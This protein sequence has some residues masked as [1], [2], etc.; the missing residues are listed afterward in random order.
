MI[1]FGGTKH[2]DESINVRLRCEN[3][4]L[5]ANI[6]GADYTGVDKNRGI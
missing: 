1:L 4:S 2:V 5:V 6:N 3:F